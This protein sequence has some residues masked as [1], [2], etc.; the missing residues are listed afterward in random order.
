M[1][2]QQTRRTMRVAVGTVLTGCLL[3]VGAGAAQAE[4]PDGCARMMQAENEEPIAAGY[5]LLYGQIDDF[6]FDAGV[7]IHNRQKM[8]EY[9]C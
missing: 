2:S 4:T 1:T 7:V 5:D 6:G 3:L 9:N 8:M